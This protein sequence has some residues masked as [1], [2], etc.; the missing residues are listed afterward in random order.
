[1]NCKALSECSRAG[2]TA[3]RARAAVSKA[4]KPGAAVL[5]V[6]IDVASGCIAP[7]AVCVPFASVFAI[8]N[9]MIIV[10][11]SRSMQHLVTLF[12]DP[13]TTCAGSSII[14][15]GSA[16]TNIRDSWSDADLLTCFCA[17]KICNSTRE[18]VLPACRHHTVCNEKF[19]SR[20]L[21]RVCAKTRQWLRNGSCTITHSW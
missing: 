6:G 5:K 10:L 8:H 9:C 13:R 1:M 18:T 11:T 20:T 19:L 21:L 4:K 15:I 3:A 14:L 7:L 2:G 16:Y 12:R 17:I